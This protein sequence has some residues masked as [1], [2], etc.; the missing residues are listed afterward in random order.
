MC[1]GT[2]RL[3]PFIF[4]YDQIPPRMLTSLRNGAASIRPASVSFEIYCAARARFRSSD[5]S[6]RGSNTLARRN[7]GAA[8]VGAPDDARLRAPP[9][10]EGSTHAAR[11]LRQGHGAK[12]P[13]RRAHCPQLVLER[14][15]VASLTNWLRA[16]TSA[17]FPL[18]RAAI[19]YLRAAQ[20]PN[21]S[22]SFVC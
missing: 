7:G 16:E 5:H 13:P 11:G 2:S 19:F 22:S 17:S 14:C 10:E 18:L 20:F 12:S 1:D 4:T 3:T 9:A 6:S 15:T 21:F 8:G